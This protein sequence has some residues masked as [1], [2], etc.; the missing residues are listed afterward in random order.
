MKSNDA[1]I[2]AL[3]QSITGFGLEHCFRLR[4]Y[5]AEI[6]DRVIEVVTKR[7]GLSLVVMMP[8]QSGKNELQAQLEAYLLIL[9]ALE[10]GDIV[11]ISPTWQPQC[12]NAIHRLERV[13]R[14]SA[15]ASDYGWRRENR[16]VIRVGDA[17]I[18]FFSGEPNSNIV[19]ATASLLLEVDEAQSVN[20]EKYDTQVAPMAAST[21][22]VRV[23]W[24]T[25]WTADTLL[26]REMR[27]ALEGEVR[28]G[29]TRAFRR[30]ADR[31]G[32]EVPE[33]ARF[34]AGQVARLG[35]THPAVR[36]QFYSEEIEARSGLFP[37]ERMA[38]VEG[39]HACLEGPRAGELYVFLVDVGGEAVQS[40]NAH[41]VN[42]QTAGTGK[43]GEPERSRHDSTALVIAAVDL[44]GLKNPAVSGPVY[45]VVRVLE[46]CG[47]G[48]PELLGRI[49]ALART[50][51][52]RRVV[53]DATGLGAGL[54][55]GL[56]RSMRGRVL[57]FTFS[58]ASK[59]RLGWDFIGAVESGRFRLPHSPAGEAGRALER[60]RAQMRACSAEVGQGEGQALRWGV[61][62]GVKDS[63]GQPLH[64]DLLMAAALCVALD[65]IE[66]RGPGGAGVVRA[67]DPLGRGE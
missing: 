51:N 63:Q 13:L 10:G 45:R 35:R 55:A 16:N 52:A 28:D 32:F 60:L 46:W 37:A 56:D 64:D 6:A 42:T 15:V 59:S 65:G 38:L 44:E 40:V 22:A 62:E 27:A 36:T 3:V 33:Y 30:D 53:V 7:E 12:L 9:F 19:G 20:I 29:L 4:L 41:H 48:Q 54:A 58:A 18:S 66:W 61:P 24:G 43:D 57:R 21:N 31:V 14:A 5:Q 23:F 47:E 39:E 2:R 1:A 11:K 50:W 26:A 67:E 25:A 49:L 17:R 34:V 8:R